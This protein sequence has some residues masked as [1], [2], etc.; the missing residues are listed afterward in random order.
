LAIKPTIFKFKISVSDLNR[1]YYEQLDLTLARHP[2]ETN[3]RMMTRVMAFCLNAQ[4]FLSFTKGLSAVEEPD[5]WSKNL[6][7][8]LLLWIDVGEPAFERIKKATRLAKHTRVYSFNSKS[9]AWWRQEGPQLSKLDA[10]FFQFPWEQIQQLSSLVERTM[11]ISVTI[12]GDSAYV[13]ANKGEVELSWQA[14]QP[15]GSFNK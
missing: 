6:S 3:E 2:S 9:D 5:I 15:E 11:D 13:A 12:T 10:Q 14:L 7:D 4:E 8:E 1:D